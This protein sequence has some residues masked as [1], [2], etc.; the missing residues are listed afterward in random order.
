[1]MERISARG[2]YDTKIMRAMQINEPLSCTIDPRT[3]QVSWYQ[4]QDGEHLVNPGNDILTFTAPQAERYRFSR[5]TAVD[6]ADLTARLGYQEVD[7]V[8]ERRVGYIYP[9][10]RAEA[11]MIDFRNKVTDDENRTNEYFATYMEARGAAAGA[12]QDIR[13]R[14]V[15]R[16]RQYLSRIES[17]VRNNPNFAL[18]TWGMELKDWE[19]DWLQAEQEFLRNLLRD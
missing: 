2:G 15:G 4:T 16:A 7:W 17:M 6:L 12:P 8:G 13:P 3:G 19:R 14:F 11:T 18:L 9:I 1:M 5:G 10:S